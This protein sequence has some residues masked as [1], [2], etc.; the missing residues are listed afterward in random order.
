MLLTSPSL[1]SISLPI[2]IRIA[3]PPSDSLAIIMYL[4]YSSLLLMYSRPL[5]ITSGILGKYP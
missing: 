2:I 3:S 1:P 4:H 5:S